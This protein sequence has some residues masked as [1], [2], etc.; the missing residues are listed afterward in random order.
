MKRTEETRH[1][2]FRLFIQAAA[3]VFMN[4]YVTGFAKGR[5]FTGRTKS[6]CV[7]VLNCH[8]CP[9]A[10]GS[11]PIGSLQNMIGRI[12]NKAAFYVLGVLMLFGIALGRLWCGFVCPF[13]L[14]QDL[15]HKIP[16]PKLTVPKKVDRPLR[17]MKYAVLAV[18]VILMPLVTAGSL[19]PGAPYFCKLICPAGT[20][21]AG[22]PL[23]IAD[24]ALRRLAGLL[25][26]WK[27]FILLTVIVGAVL[28]PRCFCRY[29]CPLG[30]IYG[31]FNRFSFYQISVRQSSCTGCKHCEQV[32]PMAVSLPTADEDSSAAAGEDM[33]RIT[34][35]ECIRC[36]KCK[37]GCPSN[38]IVSEK[39]SYYNSGKET[40]SAHAGQSE[41]S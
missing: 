11:C 36:G 18:F 39:F 29:L 4:G 38:A 23:L 7:P 2:R 22:I 21:E 6:F 13:G 16:S 14:I 5:I 19:S 10:L 34:S 32:C 12:S 3:A 35:T 40:L 28:I 26:S 8:S 25:F 31:L 37:A 33:S 20:L 1:S 41:E 9:G 17:L 24:P 15:L 30:A 27:A